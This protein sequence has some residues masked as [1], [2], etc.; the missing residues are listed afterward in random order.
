[1]TDPAD[2]TR[3]PQREEAAGLLARLHALPEDSPRRQHIR[4]LL[5]EMHLPLVRY[6]ARR[7][8]GRNAPFE[9][10]VQVG[11]IGLLK[12]IDRFDPERGLEFST[13]A[14]PTILGEIRR[15]FRDTG[16]LL[17]VPR[18]AQELQATLARGRSE[19]TQQLQRAPTV[20]E[21]ADWAGV[22]T[23]QVVEAIDA[24]RGY[25]G[26]PLDALTDDGEESR[27]DQLAET[28]T[29]LERVELREELRPA[30]EELSE[31]D[32]EILVLRFVAGK[33]QTEIAA[34]IGVSQ[35]QISR[36]ISRSLDQLRERLTANR[37]S[38][39]AM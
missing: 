17:H 22:D 27:K 9:D 7:F 6:L 23:M 13:Y 21:L 36:L 32:R 3:D 29:D 12:A 28:D 25:A 37:D 15:Y 19:L 39:R 38:E 34:I 2:A 31:R 4:D 33:T 10:I 16:W 5:A 26:V 30:L 1:V 14:T 11:A 35:M 8:T 18:R 20:S 24:A